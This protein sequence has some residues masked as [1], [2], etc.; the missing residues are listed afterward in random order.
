[1]TIILNIIKTIIITIII[2]KSAMSKKY[3]LECKE[4]WQP[5]PMIEND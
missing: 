2:M 5:L 4:K 1:M 3:D